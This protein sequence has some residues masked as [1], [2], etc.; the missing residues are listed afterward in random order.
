MVEAVL[1]FFATGVM[2]EPW[3]RTFVTLMPKRQDAA[4]PDHYRPISL[5]TTLYKVCA[6]LMMKI[7]KSILPYLICPEQRAFVSG[8]SITDNVLNRIEVYA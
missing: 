1:R 4:M 8:R 6:K 2:S 3:M 5:C 7:M